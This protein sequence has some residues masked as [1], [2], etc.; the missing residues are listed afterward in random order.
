MRALLCKSFG[1]PEDLEV[2]DIPVPEPAEGE[3]RITVHA[4][5]VNF[6]DF[7]IIQDKYQFKPQPPFAPGGEI[8]GV[9]SAVGPGVTAFKPGDKVMASTIHGAFAEEVVAKVDKTQTVPGGIRTI[10]RPR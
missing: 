2:H 5:G 6:P 1:P 8:A 7:L 10:S 9:I 3:V 4:A